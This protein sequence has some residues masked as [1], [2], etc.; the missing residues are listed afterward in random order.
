[1][2]EWP[3]PGIHPHIISAWRIITVCCSNMN[4]L[5]FLQF[6]L[7]VTLKY[8]HTITPPEPNSQSIFSSPITYQVSSVI[9][10]NSVNKSKKYMYYVHGAWQWHGY[11]PRVYEL[12]K[13]T[14]KMT[15][16]LLLR[17]QRPLPKVPSLANVLDVVAEWHC[18]PT[19]IYLQIYIA[20]LCTHSVSVKSK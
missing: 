16:N 3:P 19:R 9:P 6:L 2:W 13:N 17:Q 14:W 4:K 7:P 11:M 8:N 10:S 18:S 12:Y 1:M 15:K 20:F 5:L